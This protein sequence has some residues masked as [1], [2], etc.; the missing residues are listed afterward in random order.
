MGLLGIPSKTERA[1]SPSPSSRSRERVVRGTPVVA[2]VYASTTY[3]RDGDVR[4]RYVPRIE[5]AMADAVAL[6]VS[7]R[8]VEKHIVPQIWRTRSA[9]RTLRASLVGSEDVLEKDKD[10]RE[11]EREKRKSVSH[12]DGSGRRG[13]RDSVVDRHRDH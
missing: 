3:V 5:R 1:P 7:R 2:L 13:R 10:G 12:S 6:G 11:V 8:F 9:R 4:A